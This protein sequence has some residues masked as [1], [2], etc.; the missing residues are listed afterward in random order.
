MVSVE[1]KNYKRVSIFLKSFVV[2]S[3]RLVKMSSPSL[4]R[5]VFF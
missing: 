5:E 4:L 2:S 1:H 3:Y